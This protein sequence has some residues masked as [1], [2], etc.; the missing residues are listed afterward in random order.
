MDRVAVCFYG[1]VRDGLL[2]RSVQQ[3]FT[4]VTSDYDAYVVSHRERFEE[5]A[6]THLLTPRHR[7]R[8]P[9]VDGNSLCKSMRAHGFRRC[10]HSL[11]PYTPRPFY[12]D[13]T[14]RCLLERSL[15]NPFYPARTASLLAGYSRCMASIRQAEGVLRETYHFIVVTRLDYIS[16]VYKSAAF[17]TPTGETA[18]WP[19]VSKHDIVGRR[20]EARATRSTRYPSLHERTITKWGVLGPQAPCAHASSRHNAAN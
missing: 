8:P 2:T 20:G 4:S 18:W 12:R 6:V 5:D 14:H 10:T 19:S 17:S 15:W 16:T 3:V 13:T 7:W 9:L 11:L 1:F